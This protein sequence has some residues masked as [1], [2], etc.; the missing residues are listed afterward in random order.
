MISLKPKMVDRYTTIAVATT[1]HVESGVTPWWYD[2]NQ[3]GK[4]NGKV[5]SSVSA[6]LNMA[7]WGVVEEEERRS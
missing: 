7:E 2:V 6:R 3:T 1:G 4:R 5:A